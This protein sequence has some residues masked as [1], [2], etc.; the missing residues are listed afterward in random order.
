MAEFSRHSTIRFN[1]VQLYKHET[2]GIGSY[3]KV[4]KAKCDN[5]LCA[6][7]I[8]HET[9]FNPAVQHMIAPQREHRLP[10]RRFEQ[11]CEFMSTIRHPNIV[12]YLGMYQD[13]DTSLP[14]LLMELM[15]A[16]L[17]HYLERLAQ[18][19]PYH[20]QINLCHDMTLALSFLHLNGISHRDLSSNNVLL[21]QN[22]RAKIT[23]FGMARLGDLNPQANCP[24]FTVC[25]GT[26]VYMPPEAVLDSPKYTEKID[27]F[28]FGVI[29]IQILTRE[30]PNPGDRRRAVPS[31]YPGLPSGV[32][33]IRVP[34]I[35]RRQN[36][37]NKVD[38]NHPLLAIAL[39]CMKDSHT[40]RPSAQDLCERVAVL[41]E[42][43]EYFESETARQETLQ[44]I[45]QP[46]TY[47]QERN[48]LTKSSEPHSV[49]S[50]KLEQLHSLAIQ[51]E[52]KILQLDRVIKEKENQLEHLQQQ[53]GISQRLSTDYDSQ[54][55]RL[56]Q[57]LSQLQ[58]DK[59]QEKT[60]S[61]LQLKWREGESCAPCKTSRRNDAVVS[62]DGNL[63][64]IYEGQ[65]YEYCKNH[66]WCELPI[67]L[68]SG[69]SIAIVNDLLTAIG[70]FQDSN[71]TNQLFSLT[72]EGSS[73]KWTEQC[74][75]MPT[76]RD[77]T[78]AL[79]A[80][81]ALIV[82]GG[83]NEQ[84]VR[85]RTVEVMNTE[86]LQWSSVAHLPE[87]LYLVS[88]TSCGDSIYL[89]GGWK[90]YRIHNNSVY[91]C[92]LNALIQSSAKTL[93]GHLASALSLQ[94][95]KPKVWSRVADLTVTQSTCV[96]L[97]GQLLAIGGYSKADKNMTSDIHWYNQDTKSWEVISHMIKP[98]CK[99]FAAVLPNNQ[100]VVVGGNSESFVQSELDQTDSVEFASVK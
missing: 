16:S 96:S 23:D 60:A 8:I 52:E 67:C 71:I 3:G 84:L 64:I 97:N 62:K 68:Y 49:E 81:T 11:E 82:I 63:Y 27:C 86:T 34:E 57:Q 43:Q 83:M 24:T 21:I 7:K 4:C 75:P 13:P 42:T 46:Q 50:D 38:P 5:L 99:C 45:T 69:C 100:L 18:P 1:S 56:K 78:T 44:P 14:V 20:I 95:N 54:I 73:R 32:L 66:C 19:I 98:R 12:Q 26:D 59:Q 70:G 55:C 89:L 25:P 80:E 53:F 58:S 90:D 29:V 47:A 17:T 91:T 61:K 9:L 76:K 85:L 79:C 31:E 74:P 77:F 92:S 15:D 28:S 37:I 48:E 36:Q 72:G 10:M 40:E 51:Q 35:D 88:A 6:A 41:K 39:D 33:E 22:I 93:G 65:I 30:F 2:L 87:K 94:L